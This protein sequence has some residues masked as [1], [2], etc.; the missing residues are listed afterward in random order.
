MADTPLKLAISADGKAGAAGRRP[1]AITG[2]AARGVACTARRAQS[3]VIIG[4]STALAGRSALD[5]PSAR[6]AEASPLRVVLDGALPLRPEHVET[7]RPKRRSGSSLA[8]PRPAEDGAAGQGGGGVANDPKEDGL[9][10][11]AV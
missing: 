3:D 9:D 6:T 10:L 1:V 7:V 11:A 4:M 8:A 5:L 2:E